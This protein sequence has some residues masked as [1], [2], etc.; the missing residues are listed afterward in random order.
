MVS[1]NNQVATGSVA[2]NISL[3]NGVNNLG[4]ES[5]SKQKSSNDLSLLPDKRDIVVQ[6]KSLNGNN[7][8]SDFIRN[9]SMDIFIAKEEAEI[10]ILNDKINSS[11]TT[12]SQK[13]ILKAMLDDANVRLAK[14]KK[15][16]G[17]K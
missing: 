4:Q 3:N 6:K 16:Q 12:D 9:V 13:T 1:I 8:V 11:D 10:N 17:V 5:L 2:N 15:E 7:N 14:L